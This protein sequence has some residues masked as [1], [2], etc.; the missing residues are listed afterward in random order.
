M[1]R[2]PNEQLTAFIEEQNERLATVGTERSEQSFGLGCTIGLLPL[3]SMVLIL[4]ITGVLNIISGFFAVIVGFTALVGIAGL[5]ASSAKRRAIAD[6]YTHYV[7]QDIDLYLRE[8]QIDQ[9]IFDQTAHE[10]L[11]ESAPLRA[12]ITPL[13][14]PTES[15]EA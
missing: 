4:W 12:F 15:A 5:V 3:G 10:V 13:R 2:D 11:S 8:H 9:Q 7:K 14:E 6:T 1:D